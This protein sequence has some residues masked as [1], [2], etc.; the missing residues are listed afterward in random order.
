MWPL[1]YFE[2]NTWA[3]PE[4]DNSPTWDGVIFFIL[5]ILFYFEFYRFILNK[6]EGTQ[7]TWLKQWVIFGAIF[8]ISKLL[9]AGALTNFL[10]Y[11]GGMIL[12]FLTI[13]LIRKIWYSSIRLSQ[14]WKWTGIGLFYTLIIIFC[15]LGWWCSY[16]YFL[17]ASYPPEE[18]DQLR[19]IRRII[20]IE[21]H[22]GDLD[23]PIIPL[24]EAHLVYA[25]KEL[26]PDSIRSN[27]EYQGYHYTLITNKAY[28]P[29]LFTIDAVPINVKKRQ[30]SFHAYP[31][32][33]EG[34][35]EDFKHVGYCITMANH[36][37]GPATDK[38]R[39]FHEKGYWSLLKYYLF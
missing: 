34:L 12:V 16:V 29:A 14:K 24:T 28:Q 19:M 23:K 20:E 4:V 11:S 18:R 1:R 2:S 10:G 8:I 33:P 6:T 37:G 17:P 9:D 30:K 32:N 7:K 31:V 21:P 27:L 22:G 13:S 26:I 25:G 3:I 38:D 36:A 15:I 5:A 39:H 35:K